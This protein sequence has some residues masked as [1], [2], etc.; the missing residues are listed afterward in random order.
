MPKV[1]MKIVRQ[2]SHSVQF[3]ISNAV[4]LSIFSTLQHFSTGGE[5]DVA[6]PRLNP[7]MLSHIDALSNE[8]IQAS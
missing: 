1:N 4:T 7:S 3:S 5:K 6:T 8:N 2:T